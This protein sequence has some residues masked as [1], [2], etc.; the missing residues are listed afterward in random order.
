M[1]PPPPVVCKGRCLWIKYESSVLE[2]FGGRSPSILQCGEFKCC[3]GPL[4]EPPH[5]ASSRLTL[6]KFFNDAHFTLDIK[7]TNWL[8][9][10]VWKGTINKW[11]EYFRVWI[12][13]SPDRQWRF[14]ICCKFSCRPKVQINLLKHLPRRL[15]HWGAPT[16]GWDTTETFY[17]S[18]L[19]CAQKKGRETLGLQPKPTH[20]VYQQQSH[21]TSILTVTIIKHRVKVV[22]WS[23]FGLCWGLKLLWVKI[24]NPLRFHHRW[25]KVVEKVTD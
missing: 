18:R 8:L 14:D 17:Q 22:E 16:H 1:P 9:S 2:E 3:R 23:G 4:V 6:G 19:R 13:S 15:R 25:Y 21:M 12:M 7:N 24:R 20:S 11:G 5:F 10:S